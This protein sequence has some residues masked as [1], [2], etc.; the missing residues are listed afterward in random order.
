[1]HHI[2]VRQRSLGFVFLLFLAASN[3]AVAQE[4][5]TPQLPE[6][7]APVAAPQSPSTIRPRTTAP[8]VPQP[9]I[10]T[11]STPNAA[12]PVQVIDIAPP[13]FEP[14]VLARQGVLVETAAGRFVTSQAAD[15]GFNPAS[16]I[17]LATALAALHT[18]GAEH[19]FATSV[20]TNGAFDAATQTIRGDLIISGRDPSF[21]DAHI[22]AIARELNTMGVRTVTGDLI[23]SPGF[24]INYSPSAL[25]SGERF[26][27]ALDATRRPANATRA[28]SENRLLANDRAA[29]DTTKP[30]P[31]VAVMGAVY[32]GAA[33]AGSRVMLTHKSSAL[34]DV[35][36]VLLCYSNN[37]MAERLGDSMGGAAGLERFLV[38]E[39]GLEP[40]DVRLASTSGLGVNRLSPRSMM[41]IYRA[42]VSEL[43]ERKLRPSDIM[44]VAG[45]D[46]GTLQKRF[47]SFNARGS[48]VGKTGTLVRT[49]GGASALVGQAR[50]ATGETLYFVIF[51]QRGSVWSFRNEQ[52]RLVTQW[53]NE[54]GGARAFAYTPRP[55]ESRLIATELSQ[56]PDARATQ[57]DEYEPDAN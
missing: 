34:V 16:A 10:Y 12:T 17:K 39:V 33:P 20:W 6:R 28:W 53:Q 35:L 48:V 9:N 49:D 21:N 46:P 15:T 43:A 29:L 22:I 27:D 30:A 50:T 41:K 52:N 47:T 45:I 51:Q 40:E 44:P 11:G 56:A 54:R 37:F 19:R 57:A 13:T 31:S 42:L 1:M 14:P 5:T 7:V 55:M 26:Y 3:T 36:K 18:F 4:T 23:I 8:G 24:T 38:N 25:R 2:T 32:V